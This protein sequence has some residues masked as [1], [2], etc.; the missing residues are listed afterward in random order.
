M[1]ANSKKVCIVY[2]EAYDDFDTPDLPVSDF[3]YTHIDLLLGGDVNSK[4][5]AFWSSKGFQ[6][7]FDR[8]TNR[9]VLD[10]GRKNTSAKFITL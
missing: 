4:N 3:K 7:P 10:C 8:P 9:F 6:K 5:N 2:T 1:L